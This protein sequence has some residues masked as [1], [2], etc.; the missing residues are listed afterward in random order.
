MKTLASATQFEHVLRD[1]D[2]LDI[3]EIL[4]FR[5]DFVGVPQQRSHQAIA[6]R[7]ERDDVLTVVADVREADPEAACFRRPKAPRGAN[8]TRRFVGIGPRS[9]VGI[10]AWLD[11]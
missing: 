10:G 9:L 2:V 5:A 1:F 6:Q 8:K 3:V 4:P 11:S 7:I